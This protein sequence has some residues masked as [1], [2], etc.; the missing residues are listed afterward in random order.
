[1]IHVTNLFETELVRHF[2]ERYGDLVARFEAREM[3]FGVARAKIAGAFASSP[4]NDR[5]AS[6]ANLA[7]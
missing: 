2:L 7:K 6:L 1:M 3:L 4:A 5:F